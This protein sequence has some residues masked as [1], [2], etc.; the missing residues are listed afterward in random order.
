MHLAK[1]M[2]LGLAPSEAV[3]VQAAATIFA[4]YIGAGAVPEGR[5]EEWMKRSIKEAY[6][7]ART[8]DD[9][10]VSDNETW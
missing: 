7:I 3:V 1:K 5:S 9:A 8:T 10:I 4:A 6:F 2:A